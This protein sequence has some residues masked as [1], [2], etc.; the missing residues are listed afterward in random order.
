MEK[1]TVWIVAL[2]L[3]LFVHGAARAQQGA[4]VP[5]PKLSAD[6]LDTLVGP[7]ALYPDPMIAMILPASTVPS[8]V[9][10]AARYLRVGK[11]VDQIDNQNW[12]PSV[13]ALARYPDVLNT[14]DENLEWTNQ[15]GAAVLAQQDDVMQAIQDQRAKAN[16][17]GNLQTTPQQ[18]VII[19]KEIITIVP[20]D[21]QIIYVPQYNPQVVYVQSAP[22]AAPFITF[23]IGFAMGAWLTNDCDWYRHGFYV[24]T[25]GPGGWHGYSRYGYNSGTI[26][27]NININNS[28]NINIGNGNNYWKPNPSRPKPNP[29][30]NPNRPGNGG[31]GNLPGF[32][33]PPS[34]GWNGGNGGGN[35]P[36]NGNGNGG[37]R[38]GGGNGGSPV[39][40]SKPG[41][42]GG[43]NNGNRPGLGGG[44]GGNGGNKP[45]NGGQPGGGPGQTKPAPRPAQPQNKLPGAGG[46]GKNNFF[47]RENT[48]RPTQAQKPAPQPARQP[49]QRPAQQQ[50]QRQAPQAKPAAQQRPQ[51]QRQAGG[52]GIGGGGLQR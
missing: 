48:K 32:K 34:G 40:P 31:S 1:T 29:P 27:N 2:A 43:G 11:P 13:K 3:L 23:G 19:E 8:D 25:W 49:Q 14:M 39:F 7:I 4:D 42:G 46:G 36:G 28:N 44:T 38:P 41:N 37:N 9:V 20:A 21:P 10:L 6:Q 16:A 45:G 35:R 17:L 52:G 47:D 18:Q 15:L 33:P 5:E 24:H 22:P 26:N 12:D 30:Y 51:P 50:P